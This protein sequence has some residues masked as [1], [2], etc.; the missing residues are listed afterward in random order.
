MSGSKKIALK[1]G[2][3]CA[4]A[5]ARRVGLEGAISM[6]CEWIRARWRSFIFVAILCTWRRLLSKTHDDVNMF[7]RRWPFS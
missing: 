7:H 6:S 1:C 3:V 2:S 5:A 4:V